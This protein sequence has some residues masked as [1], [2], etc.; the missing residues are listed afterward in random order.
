[1]KPNIFILSKPIQSGKTTALMQWC[2]GK[3]NVT[4][5]LTPD[6]EGSR[7][8]YDIINK[9]YIN[10][11]AKQPFTDTN[12][13]SIGKYNFFEHVFE[14]AQQIILNQTDSDFLIIDEI[15]RLELNQNKGLEPELGIII[16]KYLNKEISSNLILVIR[17]YLLDECIEKYQLQEAKIIDSIAEIPATNILLGLVLCG[18]SSVRM[19][20]DKAFLN[21]HGKEHIYY[22]ADKMES[23]CEQ[24][25]IS[26]NESQKDKIDQ[27]CQVIVDSATYQNSGPINAILTAFELYP[28][29]PIFVLACDYPL[30][31]SADLVMLKDVFLKHKKTVSFYNNNTNFREPLIA[32]YHPNDLPHL[33]T[34]YENGNTSLKLFLNNIDAI[35]VVPSNLNSILSIDS[36]SDF[37]KT[38]SNLI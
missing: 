19:K 32:I 12:I 31:T 37:I 22:L 21:Y 26:C 6:I 9:T 38:K 33:L 7:K 11:E 18:G 17:D 3:E 5:I 10:F 1:M 27:N 29:K 25:F 23:I 4:G 34:F 20:T 24:V 28:N 30:L 16:K 2:D 13:V 36:P 8:L 15:G 35:K 14:K